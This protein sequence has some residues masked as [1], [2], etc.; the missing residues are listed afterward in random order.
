MLSMTQ[1]PLLV[2]NY[3]LA[4]SI[5]PP[6]KLSDR[7]ITSTTIILFLLCMRKFIT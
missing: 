2:A 6:I 4:T 7:I 5:L 3:F 1:I